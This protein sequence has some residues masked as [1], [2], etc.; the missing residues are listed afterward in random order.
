MNIQVNCIHNL[1]SK[2]SHKMFKQPFNNGVPNFISKPYGPILVKS[3]LIFLRLILNIIRNT[4]IFRKY[5]I[6]NY[7]ELILYTTHNIVTF[8]FKENFSL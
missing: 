2:V 8:I 6:H 5:K 3:L 1:L 7:I 4:Q